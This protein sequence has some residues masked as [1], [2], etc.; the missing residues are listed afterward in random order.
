ANIPVLG[1]GDSGFESRH[2]DEVFKPFPETCYVSAVSPRRRLRVRIPALRQI[3]EQEQIFYV[4]QKAFIKNGSEILVLNDPLE[5]LDYPGGKIQK[6]EKDIER[7]LK[8]EIL[9]ETGLDVVVGKP[10]F[11]SIDQYPDDHKHSGKVFFIVFYECEYIS[12]EIKLSEEHNSFAWVDENNF[13]SVDDNT[14]YFDVLKNYFD[15]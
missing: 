15:K 5:G 1:T 11:T 8:R 4:V 14:W 2:S 10:F 12:G 7:A 6:G 13:R 9:E 3:M